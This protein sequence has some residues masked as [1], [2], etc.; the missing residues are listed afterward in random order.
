MS[1]TESD[2]LN[3]LVTNLNFEVATTKSDAMDVDIEV[4]LEE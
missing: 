4:Q 2:D 3:N 1:N